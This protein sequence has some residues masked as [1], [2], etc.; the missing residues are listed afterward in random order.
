MSHL[1][2]QSA[3][4][5][6]LFLVTFLCVFSLFRFPFDRPKPCYSCELQGDLDAKS[7]KTRAKSIIDTRCR[8]TTRPSFLES[9]T[10]LRS[11]FLYIGLPS[12]SKDFISAWNTYQGRHSRSALC[13]GAFIPG[14]PEKTST[15]TSRAFSGGV[16]SIKAFWSSESKAESFSSSF[17]MLR[18]EAKEIEHSFTQDAC[19]TLIP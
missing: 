18:Y 10:C 8:K 14:I 7:H 9:R 1:L 11:S 19:N 17:V 12:C 5:F 13:K 6:L 16:V 15:A 4:S 2:G 3:M